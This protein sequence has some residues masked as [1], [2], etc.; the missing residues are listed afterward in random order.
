MLILNLKKKKNIL[1]S[2]DYFLARLSW[3]TLLLK[4]AS[5]K[6]KD[7]FK[8]KAVIKNLEQEVEA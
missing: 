2:S 7:A 6:A 3:L 5:F 4:L 8:W 1:N